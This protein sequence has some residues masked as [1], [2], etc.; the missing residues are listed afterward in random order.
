MLKNGW[1]NNTLFG[2]FHPGAWLFLSRSK[3]HQYLCPSTVNWSHRSNLCFQWMKQT[4]CRR[5][6]FETSDIKLLLNSMTNLIGRCQHAFHYLIGKHIQHLFY[7]G[8]INLS[9]RFS[10]MSIDIFLLMSMSVDDWNDAYLYRLNAR[11]SYCG[12]NHQ[13]AEKQV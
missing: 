1:K 7:E 11:S 2:F 9:I 6:T 13:S 12:L 8:F 5:F 4:L 10:T 3:A